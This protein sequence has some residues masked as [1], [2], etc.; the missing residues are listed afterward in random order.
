[1]LRKGEERAVEVLVRNE[2]DGMLARVGSKREDARDGR[3]CCCEGA[4][5]TSAETAFNARAVSEGEESEDKV[6]GMRDGE[7]MDRVVIVRGLVGKVNNG[8]GPRRRSRDVEGGENSGV[9]PC[10][11][12][13][14]AKDGE[15]GREE[16]RERGGDGAGRD[17]EGGGVVGGEGAQKSS[18]REFREADGKCFAILGNGVFYGRDGKHVMKRLD[19]GC[20]KRSVSFVSTFVAFT[21][22]SMASARDLVALTPL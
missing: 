1:V 10:E 3:F 21:F 12:C 14:D 13:R 2:N 22:S 6:I 5:M 15:G 16:G 11:T 8:V 18:G 7:D 20:A 19:Q 4:I 9:R 17:V